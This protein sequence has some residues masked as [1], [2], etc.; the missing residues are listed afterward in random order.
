MVIGSVV[1]RPIVLNASTAEQIDEQLKKAVLAEKW[2]EVTVLLDSV[3]AHTQS[4]VLRMIKGHACL[5]LNRNNESHRL[6]LSV[7]S[8][9]EIKRWEA[10][11]KNFV[12]ENPGD[13]VSYCFLGDAYARYGSYNDA[14]VAYNKALEHK[15]D[16]P[17]VLNARGVLY[18]CIG[19]SDKAI[20]DFCKITQSNLPLA[21]AYVNLGVT[22]VQ[23]K[24][25]TLAV[26]ELFKKAMCLSPD[27]AVALNNLAC[28]EFALGHWKQVIDHLETAR[29]KAQWFKTPITNMATFALMKDDIMLPVGNKQTKINPGMSVEAVS[30]YVTA[31]SPKE[32]RKN[33]LLAQ[34]NLERTEHFQKIGKYLSAFLSTERFKRNEEVLNLLDRLNELLKRKRDASPEEKEVIEKEIEKIRERL[35][36][37]RNQAGNRLYLPSLNEV[38]ELSDDEQEALIKELEKELEW[39]YAHGLGGSAR[40]KHI[41]KLLEAY[42]RWRNQGKPKPGA[43]PKPEKNPKPEGGSNSKSSTMNPAIILVGPGSVEVIPGPLDGWNDKEKPYIT[44]LFTKQFMAEVEKEA[45]FWKDYTKTI[46]SAHPEVVRESAEGITAEDILH[47]HVYKGK[48]LISEYGLVYP[49][50]SVNVYKRQKQ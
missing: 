28:T 1:L 47:G 35:E 19:E 20:I 21:D 6:F 46:I 23:K 44:M 38:D 16:L 42:K 25:A 34:H 43:T 41:A 18:T 32:A 12:R 11:A 17:L 29:A 10:W 49:V 3:N 48:G 9:E 40:A 45:V 33:Y 13:V 31:M 4:Q 14:L 24:T 50:S 26:A 30:Q 39:L 15:K 8:S 5:A 2:I 27:F 37:V 36:D 22:L 7:S